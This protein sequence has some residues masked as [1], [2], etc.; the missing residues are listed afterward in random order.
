MQPKLVCFDANIEVDAMVDV[1]LHC[2]KEGL[3]S[4]SLSPTQYVRSH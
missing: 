3:P 1:L 2:E 4:A